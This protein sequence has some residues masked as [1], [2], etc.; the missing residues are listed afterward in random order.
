[1]V[2]NIIL[3]IKREKNE[4]MLIDN[5]QNTYNERHHKDDFHAE[6]QKLNMLDKLYKTQDAIKNNL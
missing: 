5:I 2:K 1:M 6:F 4:Q 3:N